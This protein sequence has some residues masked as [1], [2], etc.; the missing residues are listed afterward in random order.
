MKPA[1]FVGTL[2][3]QFAASGARLSAT[4][5]GCPAFEALGDIGMVDFGL[6]QEA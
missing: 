4:Y 1:G 5:S 6:W 3:E 2:R